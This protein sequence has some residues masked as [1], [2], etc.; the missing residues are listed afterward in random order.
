V[1][2][3]IRATDHV[4]LSL[5]LT[6]LAGIPGAFL[7]NVG[8]IDQSTGTLVPQGKTFIWIAVGLLAPAA[9]ALWA[10]GARLPRRLP[11]VVDSPEGTAAELMRTT[12]DPLD[13]DR[14]ARISPALGQALVRAFGPW[15]ISALLQLAGFGLVF[16]GAMVGVELVSI[17]PVYLFPAAPLTAGVV[18]LGFAIFYGAWFCRRARH[19]GP[20]AHPNAGAGT[21]RAGFRWGGILALVI[22]ALA[23]GLVLSNP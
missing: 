7:G 1:S 14:P 10:C 15:P 3:P 8:C 13:S 23:G 18:G 19:G 12:R 17:R 6:L 5:G 20:A 4:Y 2:A 11:R 21:V 9:A 16:F 22:L